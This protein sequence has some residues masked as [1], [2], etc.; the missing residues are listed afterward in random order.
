[1][2]KIDSN[3]TSRTTREINNC[4]ISPLVFMTNHAIT[5]TKTFYSPVSEAWDS[6][7]FSERSYY[8]HQRQKG[9][10]Y[11]AC[12]YC[13]S[14][15]HEITKWKQKVSSNLSR[16]NVE[17]KCREDHRTSINN[18]SSYE[19]KA[20]KIQAYWL[21]FP[22]CLSWAFNCDDFIWIYFCIPQL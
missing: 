18:L 22:N 13:S 6:R 1:M 16:S 7:K 15:K 9:T 8:W 14:C 11:V 3:F 19:K 2:F 12:I 10:R 4:E 17:F 20:W 5:Y 21:S